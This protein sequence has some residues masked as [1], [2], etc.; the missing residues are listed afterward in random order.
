MVFRFVDFPRDSA[1]Y[2]RYLFFIVA[3]EENT[4]KDYLQL[5]KAT[6][7]SPYTDADHVLKTI[8]Y[9]LRTYEQA[10]GEQQVRAAH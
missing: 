2:H 9:I 10:Q 3:E 6:V 4:F 7:N 5:V 8:A 1:S